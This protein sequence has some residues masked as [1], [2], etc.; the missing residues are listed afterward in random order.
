MAD[1]T[2]PV[3]HAP[4]HIAAE[5]TRHSTCRCGH[6]ATGDTWAEVGAELDRHLEQPEG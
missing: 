3:E 6:V 2:P 1:P 5:P 4:V